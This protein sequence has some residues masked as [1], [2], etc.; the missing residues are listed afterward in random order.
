MVPVESLE[1][2]KLHW[3]EAGIL[4]YENHNFHLLVEALERA[5]YAGSSSL[6]L[7]LIW[8][9][10]ES[11]FGTGRDE[12]RFRISS[13]ISCFLEP[14]GEKRRLLQR[15]VAGLYDA[16]STVTHGRRLD[17]LDSLSET[18]QLGRELFFKI[19][20]DNCVPDQDS[21]MA[22]LFGSA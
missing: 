5:A 14:P 13:Y 1:W 19:V 21:L 9:A 7:L 20:E 3:F 15:K 10:L 11:L 6:A 17:E 2:I 18:Y 22:L 12:L 16:R 4:A 8:A